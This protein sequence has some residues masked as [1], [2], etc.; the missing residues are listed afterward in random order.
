MLIYEWLDSSQ[1]PLIPIARELF[2]EYSRELGIDLCFQGF[3]EEL[4]TL[5]GKYAPP[6][7]GLLVVLEDDEPIACGA[8]RELESELVELKR[9]YV[10]PDYRGHGL[11]LAITL[12]LMDKARAT[13]YRRVR[14][15][16]LRRLEPAVKLYASLGF[17]EIEPYNFNPE[18]DI[19]YLERP[20]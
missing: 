2:Q 8:L 9:I 15:D 10:R 5:P 18:P 20:L 12:G 6:R 11:G 3:A 13:G 16:T 17:V 4:A 7:G 1:H 14:L 19:V